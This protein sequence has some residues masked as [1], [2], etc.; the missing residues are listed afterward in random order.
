MGRRVQQ[1]LLSRDNNICHYCG[2]KTVRTVGHP[3]QATTEHVVPRA[4]G[5]A[6]NLDNYVLACT[7]CNGI[8]GSQLF[9]CECDYCGPRIQA[10]LDSQRFIDNMFYGIIEHNKP[11]VFFHRQALRWAV[12]L[13][14]QR[15]HFNSWEEAMAYS[16]SWKE[17]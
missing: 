12:R 1:A 11:K 17:E 3:L 13:G 7:T 2:E 4:F 8:R 15:R 10:A 16:L 9:Y 6:N 14:H 5:G